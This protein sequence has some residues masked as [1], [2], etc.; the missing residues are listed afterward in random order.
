LQTNI[1]PEL[2]SPRAV[3]DILLIISVA[4]ALK[5]SKIDGL[6]ISF[7]CGLISDFATGLVVGPQAAGNLIA[8]LTIQVFSKHVYANKYLSLAI[9]AGG[10]VLVKELSSNLIVNIFSPTDNFSDRFSYL[11]EILPLEII[12]TSILAPFVIRLFRKRVSTK[13]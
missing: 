12:V 4:G 8:C 9:L 2:I 11:L 10:A 6:L 13:V 5:F 3:P 1:I 7:L